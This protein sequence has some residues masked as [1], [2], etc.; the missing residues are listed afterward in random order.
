MNLK[1]GGEKTKK[2]SALA[3]CKRPYFLSGFVAVKAGRAKGSRRGHQS[4][5]SSK[6]KIVSNSTTGCPKDR[7]D[8]WIA[9]F[10][11]F[12][13]SK[14]ELIHEKEKKGKEEKKIHIDVNQLSNDFYA[15]MV[16]KFVKTKTKVRLE[17]KAQILGFLK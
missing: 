17:I 1:Y 8:I 5:P 9:L 12:F 11:S 6:K 10:F 7:Y 13:Q 3:L 15:H 14:Q 2:K 16:K 4:S